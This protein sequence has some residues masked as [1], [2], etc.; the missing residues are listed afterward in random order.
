MIWYSIKWSHPPPKPAQ[1]KE[2][3]IKIT[4]FFSLFTSHRVLSVLTIDQ[5]SLG[6]CQGDRKML[7]TCSSP[8]LQRTGGWWEMHPR[9]SSKRHQCTKE[10]SIIILSYILHWFTYSVQSDGFSP[11]SCLKNTCQFRRILNPLSH[12]WVQVMLSLIKLLPRVSN[13]F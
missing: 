9:T 5:H 1:S 6:D 7:N 10:D 3:G 11:H 4:S 12:V 2:E 13:H 8:M